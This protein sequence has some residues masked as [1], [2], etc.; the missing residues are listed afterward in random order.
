MD[1]RTIVAVVSIFV[2]VILALAG[3]IFKHIQN[4]D[5]HQRPIDTDKI[6]FKDVCDERSQ[7]LEDCIEGAINLG[8]IQY[9]HLCKKVDEIKELIK[10]AH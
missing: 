7:R 6:V 3:W 1:A 9:E 4:G 2:V 8:K 10:N 5:K